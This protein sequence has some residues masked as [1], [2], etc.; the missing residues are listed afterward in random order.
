MLVRV[1][2]T[3]EIK[4]VH[5]SDQD[6]NL[7]VHDINNKEKIETYKSEELDLHPK[8]YIAGKVN[9]LQ[10]YEEIFAKAERNLVSRGYRVM[11]PAV[12]GKGFDYEVY[13]PI[14]LLMLQ[15]CDAIYMLSNWT[16]SKGA[17][18]ELE[19]AKAQDKTIIYQ[20]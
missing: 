3:G 9:G 8:I 18:V 2:S 11:N 5:G 14:C 19:Y 16:D 15:A 6:G 20:D 12:L 17:K 7:Y 10:N 4:K 1:K 13:L